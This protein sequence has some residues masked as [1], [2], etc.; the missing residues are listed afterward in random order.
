MLHNQAFALIA[1]Y[2][3]INLGHGVFKHSI[4]DVTFLTVHIIRDEPLRIFGTKCE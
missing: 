4:S 1:G 3:A 2:C